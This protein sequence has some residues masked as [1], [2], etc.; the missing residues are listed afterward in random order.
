M[1]KQQLL[2]ILSVCRSR[3][4]AFNAYAPYFH[5]WPAQFYFIFPHYLIK[6]MIFEKKKKALSIKC[7]FWFSLQLLSE[8]FLVLR[9]IQPDAII[10]VHRRSRRVHFNL[11]RF[12]WNLNFLSTNFRKISN[13][14]FHETLSSGSQVV[15]YGRTDE[16][17][18][19]QTDRHDEVNSRISQF[20]ERT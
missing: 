20:C 14:Y 3:Y 12:K 6:G 19:R 2:L 17:T 5:L 4:P 7:V 10:K 18:D 1:E 11:V 15:P 9:R 13:T 16:R 8:E